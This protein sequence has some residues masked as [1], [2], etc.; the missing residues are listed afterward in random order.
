MIP[1][2]ATALISDQVSRKKIKMEILC[3]R[4]VFYTFN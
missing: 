3:I 2:F 4:T 1:V